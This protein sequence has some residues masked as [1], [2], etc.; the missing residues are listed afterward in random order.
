MQTDELAVG[1]HLNTISE[2][3]NHVN[4]IARVIDGERKLYCSS[5][6]FSRVL[7]RYKACVK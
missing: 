3:E 5:N 2:C 7:T 4:E 1:K 6:P